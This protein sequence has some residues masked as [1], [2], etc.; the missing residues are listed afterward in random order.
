MTRIVSLIRKKLAQK[1]AQ[2]RLAEIVEATRNS[3]ECQQYTRRR[4]A[5]LKGRAR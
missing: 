3:F 5:A 1:A 4:A 2:K